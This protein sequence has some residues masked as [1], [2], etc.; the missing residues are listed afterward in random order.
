MLVCSDLTDLA[1]FP[2]MKDAVPVSPALDFL[3]AFKE[4]QA[5]NGADAV[6][7]TAQLRPDVISMDLRS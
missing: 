1:V 5:S 7:I 4:Y 3:T 6:A 2:E